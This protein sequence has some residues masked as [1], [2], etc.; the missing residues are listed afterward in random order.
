MLR[1]GRP[2]EAREY[3]EKS[4]E[5]DKNSDYAHARMAEAIKAESAARKTPS[6]GAATDSRG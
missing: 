5:L 2:S 4:L 1:C 3:L 6:G